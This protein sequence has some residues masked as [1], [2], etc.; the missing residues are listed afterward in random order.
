MQGP[1]RE[2][3]GGAIAI[4]RK[5]I[6]SGSPLSSLIFFKSPLR[7]SLPDMPNQAF[8]I[9]EARRGQQKDQVKMRKNAGGIAELKAFSPGDNILYREPK[10]GVAFRK[11]GVV[12]SVRQ[13]GKSYEIK[14]EK[15]KVTIRNNR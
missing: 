2:L 3:P 8:D 10:K 1:E 14:T 6:A 9:D 5:P 13:S 7:T 12:V 11:K 15:G 4:K